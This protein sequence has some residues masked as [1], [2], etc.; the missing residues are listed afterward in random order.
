M[1]QDIATLTPLE[2]MH[3]GPWT[4]VRTVAGYSG[5]AAPRKY[6][7][8]PED[9]YDVHDGDAFQRRVAGIISDCADE[10][11]L[12]ITI[13]ASGFMPCRSMEWDL[14]QIYDWIKAA[15]RAMSACAAVSRGDAL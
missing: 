2:M 8:T 1:A 15:R 13:R 6:V 5:K 4:N 11:A 9:I 3:V 14:R 7:S 12:G 10:G